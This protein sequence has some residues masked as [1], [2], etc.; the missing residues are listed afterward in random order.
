MLYEFSCRLERSPYLKMFL[1]DQQ[2]QAE[3]EGKR[4][5]T[6]CMQDVLEKNFGRRL[7]VFREKDGTYKTWILKKDGI[8]YRV[9][10][11]EKITRYDAF[12]MCR[13]VSDEG[14]NGRFVSFLVDL[15][16]LANPDKP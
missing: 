13:D 16:E 11:S 4:S 2:R 15:W 6:S 8:N 1:E 10:S 12:L 14:N 5:I 3:K 9:S 7:G